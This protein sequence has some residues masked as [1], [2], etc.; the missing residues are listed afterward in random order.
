VTTR[1]VLVIDDDQDH[2]V[3]LGLLLETDGHTVTVRYDGVSAIDVLEAEQPDLVF[4]DLDM[5]GLN[6]YEL[7]QY[8]RNRPWGKEIYVFALTGWAHAEPD[9]LAAGFDGCLL[10][11]S[12]LETLRKF[13]SRPAEQSR[14]RGPLAVNGDLAERDSLSDAAR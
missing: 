4:L 10:K 12:G 5:P 9:A 11:P 14:R 13:L 6:G 8:I 2:A 3:S 1:R 7:C